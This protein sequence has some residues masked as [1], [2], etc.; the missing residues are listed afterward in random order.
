MREEKNLQQCRKTCNSKKN[1]QQCATL[2]TSLFGRKEKLS[3][4]GGWRGG[5]DSHGGKQE[6]LME[7]NKAQKEVSARLRKIPTS[8][9]AQDAQEGTGTLKRSLVPRSG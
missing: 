2:P 5:Q 9:G 8:A 4:E 7:A 3:R 1:L 6:I